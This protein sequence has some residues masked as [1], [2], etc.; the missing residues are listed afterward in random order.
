MIPAGRW[1]RRRATVQREAERAELSSAR[2]RRGPARPGRECCVRADT[3]LLFRVIF[4]CSH[5]S[6][7]LRCW[8]SLTPVPSRLN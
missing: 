8:H 3:C 1:R 7:T 4:C 6:Y 2:G 5:P